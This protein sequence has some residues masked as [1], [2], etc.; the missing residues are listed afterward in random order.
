MTELNFS[1]Q[2]PNVYSELAHS[3]VRELSAIGIS[4]PPVDIIREAALDFTHP[5]IFSY[6]QELKNP[7]ARMDWHRIEW[8]EHA[9]SLGVDSSSVL[10]SPDLKAAISAALQDIENLS[11]TIDNVKVDDGN[12]IEMFSE[13]KSLVVI[14]R[15]KITNPIKDVAARVQKGFEKLRAS[16]AQGD[17]DRAFYNLPGMKV[18]EA[19]HDDIREETAVRRRIKGHLLVLSPSN[20]AWCFREMLKSLS[21]EIKQS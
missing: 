21:I 5:E 14:D 15:V 7:S 12:R 9:F 6:V 19:L 16:D 18:F 20:I 2:E 3:L 17:I 1:T 8:S 10:V 4:P 11:L 13:E